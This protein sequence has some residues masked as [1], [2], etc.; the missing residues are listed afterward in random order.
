MTSAREMRILAPTAILGYGFPEENFQRG[1]QENPH[2]IAVDAGS[3]DPGP[4]YLGKGKSFT[5]RAGV[6]RDLRLMLIAAM[7][8]EIPVLI[9]SAGGAGGTPHLN[10]TVKIIE[11]IAREENMTFP[12]A[13]IDT[14]MN[15]DWLV[16]QHNKGAI[17]ELSQVEAIT[18]QELLNSE[19][20]VAQIGDAPF[21]NALQQ[22]AK[23]IVSGRAYDPAMFAALP[24]MEDY[25]AGLAYHMGKILECAAIAS[26]PGSGRDVMLGVLRDDE[27]L[28][29]PTSPNRKCTVQ[30]VAAH[31][32]YEKSDPY[33]LYGPGGYLDLENTEYHQL[34]EDTV[35][36][37]GTQFVPEESKTVKLEGAKL[38]GYRTISIAGTRDPIM[39]EQIDEITEQIKE[40]VKDNFQREQLVEGKDY[41]LTFRL[42]GKNGVM[43]PL[44]PEQD[45][46]PLEI[47][48]VIET[49]AKDQDLADTITSYAR[50]TMLHYGYENRISTAGNL[51]FP[52]SPSDIPCGEVYE[53]NVHHL[54][55]LSDGEK[56]G[57]LFYPQFKEVAP[58]DRK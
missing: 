6:K 17:T 30:S 13:T 10:W 43:G 51:A 57:E 21:Q 26:Q 9:G 22:G 32:L 16:E 40:A 31:T 44:E 5:N 14:E 50:S 36:V 55:D 52:Y 29:K 45:H 18:E 25:P 35:K 39:I 27:F 48:I 1:L 11:E 47:G 12:M 46:V 20:V 8:Y 41:N 38:T 15:R 42:Y 7:E 49:V 37:T 3:V 4:Y 53:F 2:A 28:L 56:E 23:V 54:L 33:K 19:R 24:L 58:D 34:T